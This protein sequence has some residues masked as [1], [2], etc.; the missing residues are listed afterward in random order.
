MQFT[1]EHCGSRYVLNDELVPGRMYRTKCKSCGSVLV[2]KGGADGTATTAPAPK[3]STAASSTPVGSAAPPSRPGVPIPTYIG[4]GPAPQAGE[5]ARHRPPSSRWGGLLAIAL[6][7]GIAGAALVVGLVWRPW[8]QRSA[9]SAPTRP[10]SPPPPIAVAPAPPPAAEPAASPAAKPSPD[11]GAETAAATTPPPTAKA[12]PAAEPAPAAPAEPPPA[13][14]PSRPV[15]EERAAAKQPRPTKPEKEKRTAK[16][17]KPEPRDKPAREKPAPAPAAAEGLSPDA[18]QKVLA[19]GHKA[20]DVCLQDPSRGLEKPL[21]AR[22]VRLRFDVERDGSATGPSIDDPAVSAAPV[23]Q[24]LKAA[25]L[26]LVFP[27][28][29]GESIRVDTPVA[30]PAAR[31]AAPPPAAAATPATATVAAAAPPATPAAATS[32][33]GPLVVHFGGIKATRSGG[34]INDMTYS[35]KSEDAAITDRQFADGVVTWTGQVGFGKG[36]RWAG[37]GVT[38]NILPGA[39]AIDGTRFKTVTFRLASATTRSLRL[40]LLGADQSVTN[41][42]CYPITLQRVSKDLKEYT[43]KVSEFESEAFCSGRGRSA[44]KTLPELIGFE[45]AD[46]NMQG[47]PSSFSIGSITLNP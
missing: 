11:E 17:E 13:A 5:P 41:A 34:E 26:A 1:C 3:P 43:F 46:I 31:A 20:F 22:Q 37:F 21:E 19:S 14:K 36:S 30:I 15:P 40:R 29:R 16:V 24:C 12:A 27:P 9:P 6:V 38:V 18:I 35:E 44:A 10:V 8:A 33:G 4:D 47:K 39:K 25:A 42:G 2:L 7:A 28:F 32:S 23:G 45:I